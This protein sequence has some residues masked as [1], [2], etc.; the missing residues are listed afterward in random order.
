[1]PHSFQFKHTTELD[2]VFECTK[3][4]E[5]IG[6]N[7]PGIGEPAAIVTDTGYTTPENPDQ[8]SVP[9]TEAN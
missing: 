3:C 9:C 8:W 6:F 2:A 7:L 4:G 1:M 5:V